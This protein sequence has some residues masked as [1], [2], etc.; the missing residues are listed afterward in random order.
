MHETAEHFDLGIFEVTMPISMKASLL[1]SAANRFVGV[2][3]L[4]ILCLF[5]SCNTRKQRENA[6]LKEAHEKR[7]VIMQA[8]PDPLS[9]K[10]PDSMKQW[11]PIFKKVLFTDQKYRITGYH[12]TVQESAEQ[13]RLDS[14]NLQTVK[15]FLDKYGWPVHSMAGYSGKTAVAMVIQHAA[16]Q[17]QEKYY[18]LLIE[19]TGKDKYHFE[20]LALLEDRINVRKHRFQVYGTQVMQYKGERVLYPVANID[21]L[22]HYRLS[23]G[24]PSIATYL[25][26]M[27][28]EWN[29][30]K[31]KSLL[32]ELRKVF[33]VSDTP[34]VRWIHLR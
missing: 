4:M 21:S 22:D 23:I 29:L 16:L 17:V 8:L 12:P 10:V 15:G 32:P 33:K 31:Y 6:R 9:G 20:T 7:M 25:Q 1:H 26:F 19:A 2:F 18:P 11:I 5:A 14:L 27:K 3:P 13:Q 30:P 28:I 24:L 34:A